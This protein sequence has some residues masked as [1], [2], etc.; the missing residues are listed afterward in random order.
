MARLQPNH[1]V[2]NYSRTP[3][4]ILQLHK[5]VLVVAYIMFANR[6]IFLVSI[7]RHVKFT[8]V[9]YI[10][11]GTTSDRSNSLGK[12]ND[13]YYRQGMFLRNILYG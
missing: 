5:K 10:G 4:E 12:I 9:K 8:M 11:K 6:I 7:Y 1:V 13:I 2:S 3:K